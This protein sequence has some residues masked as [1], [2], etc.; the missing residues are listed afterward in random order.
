MDYRKRLHLEKTKE[1]D[2]MK[3]RF[4]LGGLAI[5]V[6]FACSVS[7]VQGQGTSA[8]NA[9]VIFASSDTANFK[10]VAPGV[11]KAVL[12]GD[13]NKG[14]YGLPPE[15]SSMRLLSPSTHRATLRSASSANSGYRRRTASRFRVPCQRSS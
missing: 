5:V 15:R 2:R 8:Q 1:E 14:A 10:E 12:W 6:V 7:Y 3:R 13:D 11:S 4:L 9:E